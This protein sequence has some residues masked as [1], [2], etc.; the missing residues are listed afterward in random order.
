MAR[1]F[2]QVVDG[3]IN[4][5]SEPDTGARRLG[6]LVTGAIV[7]IVANKR[8]EADGFV[9]VKH[10]FGWSV[11]RSLEE[12]AVFMQPA[13]ET[14]AL[15]DPAVVL[16]PADD[17]SVFAQPQYFEVV[18]GPLVIRAEPSVHAARV[19]E[20]PQ[21]AVIAV[22]PAS[23][24]LADGF[25]WW[26]HAAGWTA[27]SADGGSEI[28]LKP[29]AA[30]APDEPTVTEEEAESQTIDAVL[31]PIAVDLP[32]LAE[33]T[34]VRMMQ[35]VRGPVSV[36]ERPDVSSLK[37]GELPQGVTVE[38][39]PGSR[40]V[41]GDYVYWQ[42]SG[43]WS[44]EGR[45]DGSQ[46][47]MRVVNLASPVVEVPKPDNPAVVPNENRFLKVVNGPVSIRSYPD[48]ASQWIGEIPNE[49]VIEVAPGSRTVGGGYVYY[50]HSRGWS[51]SGSADGREVYMIPSDVMMPDVVV[52]MP[53]VPVGIFKVVAGPIS[54]RTHPSTSSERIGEL[55]ENVTIEVDP[56]SM[57]IADEFVW[58]RHHLGWSVERRVDNRGLFMARVPAMLNPPLPQPGTWPDG[59]PYRFFE[60]IDGPITIRKDPDIAAERTGTLFNGEQ[61]VVEPSSRQARGGMVWWR[62]PQGWSVERPIGGTRVFM[63]PLKAL[64]RKP[65]T[66]GFNPLPIFTRH[67]L[68]LSD[69]QWIQ[70]FGN[71]RF[72]Y[73]LR[74]R[75]LYWY[76][77]CQGLHGGFDYGTNRALPVVAGV[78]GAVIDV[79]TDTH[80]YAPNFCRVRVGPFMVIYGHLA[81]PVQF[82]PGTT[83]N[84][85]T[86]LGHIE[87]GGQNHVHLEVRYR[88]QIVNPLLLMPDEMREQIVGRW[89]DN[90][91]HF[92]SSVVWDQ[93]KTPFDQ[94]ILELQMKGREQIIGPHA[95]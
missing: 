51:A 12:H 90:T 36:R 53:D 88:N 18:D 83:V 5:R 21:N 59:S 9:W 75:K 22:D 95:T 73:N 42:H 61:I 16:L 66:G 69:T 68:A 45:L 7:E 10:R 41:S 92:Y 87:A 65:S 49:M 79:R 81:D 20:L 24:T 60:V 34:T 35:V 23:R 52:T 32:A 76:N 37:L 27:G 67:P 78:Q 58:W 2:M 39:V 80:V 62:H 74:V 86:V 56:K 15:K 89:K 13:A 77:Y 70:Y 46:V 85:D 4:V 72:A 1:Q 26:K 91:K 3:P 38:V 93:W 82:D 63:Q 47:F 48:P 6:E 40:T 71:T 17:P 19:G 54:I 33:S 30:P 55:P 14:L 50:R 44:A 84:P 25:V 94:P 31:A 8:L 28:S 11:E 57:T 43:G 29:V 64:T